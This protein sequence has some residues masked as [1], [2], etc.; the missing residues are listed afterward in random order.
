MQSTKPKIAAS[1]TS[2]FLAS[3]DARRSSYLRLCFSC[4]P[5]QHATQV[6]ICVHFLQVGLLGFSGSHYVRPLPLDGVTALL[7]RAS[8]M[9]RQDAKIFVGGLSAET[10]DTRLRQYFENFGAVEEAFVSVDRHTGRP[11]GFGFVL[12]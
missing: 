6:Y 3:K 1:V 10:D 8:K 12:F 4:Q 2:P 5:R 7:R 11:S 9:S